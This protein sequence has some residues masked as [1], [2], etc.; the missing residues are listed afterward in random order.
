MLSKFKI[1]TNGGAYAIGAVA[2][3][4]VRLLKPTLLALS[5]LSDN[6]PQMTIG[7]LNE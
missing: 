1:H 5:Q 6:L 4:V 3:P 2:I 7:T